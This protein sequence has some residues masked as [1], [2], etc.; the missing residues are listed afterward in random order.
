MKIVDLGGNWKRF[1]VNLIVLGLAT[2][3]PF[4]LSFGP[5]VLMVTK[6][7]RLIAKEK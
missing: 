1:L 4:V 3:I 2:L 5:F 6:N 7:N